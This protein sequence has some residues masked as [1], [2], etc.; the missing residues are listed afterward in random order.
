M[1]QSSD[2]MSKD[3][4]ERQV[5]ADLWERLKFLPSMLLLY[6]SQ[7]VNTIMVTHK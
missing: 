5:I 2:Q 7:L 6:G 1:G 4:V 3:D